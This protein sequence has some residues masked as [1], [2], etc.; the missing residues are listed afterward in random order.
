MYDF[1]EELEHI[2]KA[3]TDYYQYEAEEFLQ[4]AIIQIKKDNIKLLRNIETFDINIGY[5][6]KE[7]LICAG[8]NNVIRFISGYD[9]ETGKKVFEK[10]KHTITKIYCF[11]IEEEKNVIHIIP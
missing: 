8:I 3:K 4:K 11:K 2:K 1:R 9:L 5:E 7:V 10:I 6:N